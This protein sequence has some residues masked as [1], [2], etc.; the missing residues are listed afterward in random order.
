[1]K[2][3][4]ELKERDVQICQQM[5]LTLVLVGISIKRVKDDVDC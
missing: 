4:I 2:Q 3:N 5:R 1:M